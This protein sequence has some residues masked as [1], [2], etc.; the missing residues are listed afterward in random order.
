[1]KHGDFTGL[2]LNYSLYRP[3]YSEAVLDALMG[4]SKKPIKDSS[5]AD[6]GAG[7]G[8]WTRMLNKKSPKMLIAVEP[9]D[10]MRFQ[11]QKDS[12]DT[13]VKW[14]KGTGEKTGLEDRSFDMVFMASSFHW[15]DFHIGCKEFHRILS[16]KGRFVA[17]WNP[18]EISKNELL[19]EFE[20]YL[21]VLEPKLKR[22]SSGFSSFANELS[23]KLNNIYFKNVVYLES[24]NNFQITPQQYLGAWR[25]VN[26]IQHQLGPEK[27]SK[28]L[29]YIEEKMSTYEY[30]EVSYKTRAWSAEKR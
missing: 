19:V 18:R 17:I 9:N 25:S 21:Y 30:L 5:F 1:M 10:D 16:E 3:G 24:V 12:Q 26:D 27:F 14:F 6:V 23:D 7:T 8:I 11:G 15:I 22:V 2:A 20:N 28:F 29:S 13:Q 4:L